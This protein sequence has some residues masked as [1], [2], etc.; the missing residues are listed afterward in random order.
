MA[1]DNPQTSSV[2]FI[3]DDLIERLLRGIRL[4]FRRNRSVRL[5][6]AVWLRPLTLA[7]A[8]KL[9]DAV[10]KLE[11]ALGARRES[12]PKFTAARAIFALSN[13]IGAKRSATTRK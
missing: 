12:Q 9:D 13:R 7:S 3:D 6:R 2:F 4:R 10:Q 11:S 5:F 8:G 1:Q